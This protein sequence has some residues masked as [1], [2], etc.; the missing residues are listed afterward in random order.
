M[1]LLL[2]ESLKSRVND[3]LSVRVLVVPNLLLCQWA[4]RLR[5][6]LDADNIVV[7]DSPAGSTWRMRVG[8]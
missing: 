6:E 8:E 7:M 2:L 5:V 1:A 3:S 4:D